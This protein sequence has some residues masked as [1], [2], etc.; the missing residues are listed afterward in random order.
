M[1]PKIV[2]YDEPTAGLDP[3]N[4]KKIQEMILRLKSK[5]V[6]SIFVS[7]DMPSAFAVCDRIV[8]LL[9]GKI[10]AE[11]TKNDLNSDEGGPIFNFI[12][13]NEV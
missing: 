11:G 6:T 9:N 8:L 4:T 13:G 7:H 5:G 2:L 1:E 10:V 3:F 12:H